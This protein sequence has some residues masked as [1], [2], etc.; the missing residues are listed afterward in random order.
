MNASQRR[1][2]AIVLVSVL[3]LGTAASLIS[4]LF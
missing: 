3:V 1:I 4:G 2:V